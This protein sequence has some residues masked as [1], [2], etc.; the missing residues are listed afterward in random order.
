MPHD[1][2]ASLPAAELA[3]HVEFVRRLARAIVGDREAADEL[4]S[5]ALLAGVERPP[6]RDAS[7]RAWLTV[8]V[9][10]LAGR[11]RRETQRRQRREER[12]ASVEAL[13]TTLEMAAQLESSRRLSEAFA[14]LAEPYRRTLFLRFFEAL[15]PAEIAAREQLPLATVKSRLARGLEALRGELLDGADR[16]AA[17]G[18]AAL[19]SIPGA[20]A[21]APLLGSV[22]SAAMTMKAKSWWAAALLCALAGV[23]GVRHRLVPSAPEATAERPSAL[24]AAVEPAPLAGAGAAAATDVERRA[25][26]EAAHAAPFASGLVVDAAGQPLADV[27]VLAGE[28]DRGDPETVVEPPLEWGRAGALALAR[29]DRDGRFVVPAPT[30]DLA[31]L[32]FAKAGFALGDVRDLAGEVER[33]QELRV[34]LDSGRSLAVQVV[35]GDGRPLEAA[36]VLFEPLTADAAEPGWEGAVAATLAERPEFSRRVGPRAQA[37]LTGADGLARF[38]ALP[39]AP[40]RLTAFF[41]GCEF[42]KAEIA[43]AQAEARLVVRRYAVALDVRDATS[44]APLADAVALLLDPDDGRVVMELRPN[45]PEQSSPPWAAA[46]RPGRLMIHPS[47]PGVGRRADGRLGVEARVVAPGHVAQGISVRWSEGEEPPALA[48]ALPRGEGELSLSGRVEPP[49]AA[50]LRLVA[51]DRGSGEREEAAVAVARSGADGRFAL[52]DAPAGRWLL[53]T[54]A[55]GH[56]TVEQAVETPA[57]DLVV[58]LVAEARLDVAVVDAAGGPAVDALVQLQTSDQRRAWRARS[59]ADGVARFV[60]LPAGDYVV[61]AFPS[62]R[63]G[64]GEL[65]ARSVDPAAFARDD[66]LTLAAGEARAV[67]RRLLTRQ[68]VRLQVTDEAG[69]P[70]P[71]A[72]LRV[73]M[74]GGPAVECESRWLFGN[75]Q[76]VALDGEGRA[77]LPLY[78]GLYF[79]HAAAAGVERDLPLEVGREGG[80]E[81]VVQLPQRLARG[82]ITCRIVDWSSGAPLANGVAWASATVEG[83]APLELGERRSDGEGVCRW[84]GVPAGAIEIAVSGSDPFE[85]RKRADGAAAAGAH[86]YGRARAT[87]ELG[88]DAHH[89]IELRL[90]AEG[91][92]PAGAERVVVALRLREAA[93][94][95]ALAGGEV[96]LRAERAGGIVIDVGRFLAD[97]EGRVRGE[98]VA[99]ERYLLTAAGPSR[100]DAES[101]RMVTNH[102]AVVVAREPAAGEL[103]GEIVLER[104]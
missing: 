24:P 40:G 10:R 70:L 99:C 67:E 35:A 23:F 86:S 5:R 21:G 68:S 37:Q 89:E 97:D 16:S 96:E 61:A 103:S 76:L 81:L 66:A 84:E 22:G 28:L 38:D 60:A 51:L 8:V 26:G 74:N 44:G 3:A 32:L 41:D 6:P 102:R 4:A 80:V 25:V 39:R 45:R 31:S 65:G 95:A 34:V 1:P 64:R 11:A 59:G 78:P 49:V 87:F 93:T 56:A 48:V 58:P 30:R 72:T 63:V 57:R 12:A 52:H 54:T 100:Y 17:R 42:A 104:R 2:A 13:P 19:A 90:V 91:P 101:Q 18:L 79:A 55:K 88:A 20:A 69:A 53:I 15:P 85:R 73:R 62:V 7:W 92:P 29:S 14:R 47:L 75:G 83:Q 50:T 94:G 71:G 9:R 98:V 27:A 33:R 82:A 77:E 43:A 36:V 46:L